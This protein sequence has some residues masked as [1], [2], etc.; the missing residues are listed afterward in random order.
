MGTQ[1]LLEFPVPLPPTPTFG[2]QARAIRA[3][4]AGVGAR[5]RFSFSP[6][7]LYC[8]TAQWMMMSG[9][10]ILLCIMVFWDWDYGKDGPARRLQVAMGIPGLGEGPPCDY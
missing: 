4:K 2:S 9:P 3:C 7:A 1:Q 8:L 6:Q 5:T 10:W